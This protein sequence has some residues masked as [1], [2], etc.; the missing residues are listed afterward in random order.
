MEAQMEPLP[1]VPAT[2]MAGHG[3]GVRS[4]SLE[5]RS[6]PGLIM[7]ERQGARYGGINMRRFISAAGPYGERR[8]GMS[9]LCFRHVHPSNAFAS[10][11]C[12]GWKGESR[13]LKRVRLHTGAS[14]RRVSLAPRHHPCSL[15]APAVV[16]S[17]PQILRRSCNTR[18]TTSQQSSSHHLSPLPP[19]HLR[20]P[21]GRANP[22]HS[23]LTRDCSAKRQWASR[24]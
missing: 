21:R 4:R 16:A 14:N 22:L 12:R 24:K 17:P 2:W 23:F 8:H 13:S 9:L 11:H 3:R 20:S 5:M 6:S 19:S 18:A 10:A 1:L 15:G 7:V